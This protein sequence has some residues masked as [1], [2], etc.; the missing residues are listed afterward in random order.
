LGAEAGC[1]GTFKVTSNEAWKVTSPEPWLKI[2]AR[3]SRLNDSVTVTAAANTL[4]GGRSTVVTLTT[5]SRK[6]TVIVNQAS[7]K[8]ALELPGVELNIGSEANSAVSFD[9]KSNTAWDLVVVNENVQSTGFGPRGGGNWLTISDEV[10]INNKTI[11]LSASANP[12][13]Q[14]RSAKI[15]VSSAG[16]SPKTI[17]VTQSEGAP[18]LNIMSGSLS[19]D[20]EEGSSASF[21]VMSNTIWNLKCSVPWLSA[22]PVTGGNF[23]QVTITAKEN[24]GSTERTG[25]V[26]VTVDG[27][28]PRVI[29]VT[30]KGG[31]K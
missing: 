1:A 25:N 29:E 2:N 21:R 24:S 9:I 10:G 5:K 28:P 15:T 22:N 31:N 30:Q 23:S 16:L 19:I 17:T 3:S 7:S 18:T 12:G 6:V 4:K 13:V 11:S 14:K 26:I 8:P 27:L 20:A